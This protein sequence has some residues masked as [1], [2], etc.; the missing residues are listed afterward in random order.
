MTIDDHNAPSLNRCPQ[1]H[2]RL[3]TWRGLARVT[4]R[5][6]PPFRTNDDE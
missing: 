1:S 6:G 4:V 2:M 5:G 3:G